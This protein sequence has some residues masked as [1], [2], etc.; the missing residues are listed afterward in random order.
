MI[1]KTTSLR[2]K[3]GLLSKGLH[4]YLNCLSSWKKIPFKCE[5]C[6]Y[7]C[8]LK[9]NMKKYIALVHDKKMQIICKFCNHQ[10]FAKC[11]L[12]RDILS[13]HKTICDFCDNNYSLSRGAG[14]YKD[15]RTCP[16]HVL[17][18]SLEKSYF[19]IL[20]WPCLRQNLSCPEYLQIRSAA[21][22]LARILE[23]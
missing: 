15:T 5:I 17:R 23:G 22:D 7:V 4:G 11:H 6:H 13:V 18:K 9:G 2:S 20:S 16:D 19:W 10:N 3:N 12:K 21:P 8:S 14:T 1:Y